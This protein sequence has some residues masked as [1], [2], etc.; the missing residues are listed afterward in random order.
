MH[1]RAF[2]RPQKGSNREQFVDATELNQLPA[3]AILIVKVNKDGT[4]E[5]AQKKTNLTPKEQV[6]YDFAL[7]YLEPKHDGGLSREMIEYQREN[8]A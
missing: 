1:Y 2:Y 7:R 5:I 6:F 8:R 4:R 3:G